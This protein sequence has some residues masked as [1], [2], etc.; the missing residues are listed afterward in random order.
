V[1][2]GQ[3]W[4]SAEQLVA[5]AEAHGVAPGLICE[6]LLADRGLFERSPGP[7][8]TESGGARA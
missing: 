6:W 5:L 3:R 4:V 7:D 1:E 8:A 2:R